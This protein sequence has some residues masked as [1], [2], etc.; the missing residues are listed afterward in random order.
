MKRRIARRL[1]EFGARM[2]EV[3]GVVHLVERVH[4]RF[5][6][7]VEIEYLLFVED[8][9][10]E[11]KPAEIDGDVGSDPVEERGS[12]LACEIDPHEATPLVGGDCWW[13]LSGEKRRIEIVALGNTDE[14]TRRVVDPAVIR[15]GESSSAARR[16]AV[17]QTYSAVLADVVEGSDRTVALARDDDGVAMSH[18]VDPVAGGGQFARTSREEPRLSD[19]VRYLQFVAQGVGIGIGGN[20]AVADVGDRHNAV[21]NS[22]RSV[23]TRRTKD[24]SDTLIDRPIDYEAGLEFSCHDAFMPD[25]IPPRELGNNDLVMSHFTL[26]RHCPIEARVA[27]AAAAGFAGIGLYVGDYQ[28]LKAAGQADGALDELLDR[29][30]MA[31][32]EIEVVSSWARPGS[33]DRDFEVAAWE[34][35]DRWGCRYMQAIGP[36]DGSITD[37]GNAYG[38][39]CDRAADHGLV[40]GLEFLPFTNIFDAG[41]ALRIVEVADRDNGGICVDIWHHQ[42]GAND[43]ALIAAIPASKV[44][45][46]QMSDGTR[47]QELPDYKDDC[48][49][50]RVPLGEGEFDVAGFVGCLRDKGVTVPWSLEVCRDLT[51]GPSAAEHVQACADSMR[52]ALAATR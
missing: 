3:V 20:N 22:N 42:R 4:D 18:I 46:I 12:V 15:T 17:C 32:A 35:A 10:V 38:A 14:F 28:R 8:H 19:D 29:Y 50:R 23:T 11:C 36:Y 40:V 34:M 7:H 25:P 27:L 9:S 49:K 13:T 43:L 30:S 39:L 44:T 45:G 2:V 51:N 48:L 6:A 47:V 1:R 16:L 33:D 21:P 31:I 41:D 24:H 52:A 5:V 26:Q 37:A